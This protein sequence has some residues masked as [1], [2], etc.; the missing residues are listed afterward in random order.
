MTENRATQA[1]KK[2][3]K[4]YLVLTAIFVAI[5]AGITLLGLFIARLGW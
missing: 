5:F 2:T 3:A 1:R 4:T